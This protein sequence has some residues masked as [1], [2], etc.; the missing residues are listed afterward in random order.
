MNSIAACDIFGGY[1][2]VA[3]LI[4]PSWSIQN[5]PLGLATVASI[6]R[7]N[8]CATDVYDLNILLW[9]KYK[10]KYGDKWNLSH[11]YFWDDQSRSSVWEGYEQGVS[12]ELPQE[13]IE[14]ID[15]ILSPLADKSYDVI[16]FSIFTSNRAATYHAMRVLREKLPDARMLFGGPAAGDIFW[17]VEGGG[18][19]VEYWL[20]ERDAA[21]IGEA[22]NA[23]PELLSWWGSEN[24]RQPDGVLVCR[25]G[26]VSYA[27]ST[28]SDF[29]NG[30]DPDY[31][32]YDIRLYTRELLPVEITRGCVGNCAFCT[33]KNLYP[34]YRVRSIDHLMGI[35]ERGM[36]LHRTKT[37]NF[38]GSAINGDM[39]YFTDFCNRIVE[40]GIKILWGGSIRID[41]RMDSSVTRIMA[42]AGCN[43]VNTGIESAAPDVLKKMNKVIDIDTAEVV[44]RRLRESG[45]RVAV[46]IISG[47]PGE[48]ED[49]H[50]Q[51]IDFLKRLGKRISRVH[52]SPCQVFDG[53]HLFLNPDQYGIAHTEKIDSRNW[54]TSD[55]AN[56]YPVR[57]SR[58]R[59]IISVLDEIGVSWLAPFEISLKS[60][61]ST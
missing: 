51:T 16:A 53:S 32:D 57:E 45:I 29:Y 60:R 27:K 2:R 55:N 35:F 59:E 12:S 4:M 18:S 3:L 34:G 1:M 15:Q 47:F 46:N 44:I 42:L 50:L 7:S 36:E 11:P 9:H 21:I 54:I 61:A 38:I 8:G 31:S 56:D 40:S 14:C 30:L 43:Y 25:G 13:I 28:P 49:N 24:R 37:F 17:P 20:T 5:L 33:E 19:A 10:N 39:R 22:E 23:L 58:V 26:K 6:F 41:S 48:T 52:V